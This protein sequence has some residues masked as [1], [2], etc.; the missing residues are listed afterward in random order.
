MSAD[1]DEI[2]WLVEQTGQSREEVERGLQ[3][4]SLRRRSVVSELLDAG[5]RGEELLQMV[6]RLTGFPEEEARKLIEA[7]S[8]EG[9]GPAATP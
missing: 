5:L 3:E 4:G 8:R 1:E 6:V 7:E 2:A 9:R